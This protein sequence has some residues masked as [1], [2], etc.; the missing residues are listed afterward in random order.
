MLGQY[1]ITFREVLEAALIT[2][3]VLAYLVRTGRSPLSRY[4]WYGVLSATVGSVFLGASIWLAYGTLPKSV[5]V[6]FEGTAAL[7]AV[8]VLSS[9]IY[10]MATRGKELR[11]E[12]ERRVEAIATRGATL[13]LVSFA[14]VAVFREGLETVLFLT[15]FMV[16]DTVGTIAG[17]SLGVLTSLAL[18]YGIFIVGMKINIRRFFYFTSILL[19]LLAGGLA[20]YGVHELIE[21]TGS[22]PW[23]WVGQ[24]AYNLNIPSDSLFHH[25]GA[26]GSVFAVMFGYTVKAEW[27]RVIVHLSYLAVV[28]PLVI[29][30][31]N[32]KVIAPRT[33]REAS[34]MATTTVEP[35]PRARA[36]G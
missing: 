33:V 22:A 26:I 28:L 35:T 2:S 25:K 19:V 11:T 1:L 4:V 31:Y 16:T 32:R 23:G 9:M 18:A 14:F 24:S 29:W 34:T 12:V 7:I 6:L 10:W 5:Q 17:L 20:G 30:V 8:V 21:Y 13:G 15:P 36:Q 3:I 27:A